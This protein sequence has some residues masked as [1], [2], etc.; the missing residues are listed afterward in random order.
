MCLS[1]VALTLTVSVFR[2]TV[3]VFVHLKVCQYCHHVAGAVLILGWNPFGFP[4]C[5]ANAIKSVSS[6]IQRIIS[7]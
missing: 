5:N 1:L 7:K 6:A 4:V 3:S 2:L